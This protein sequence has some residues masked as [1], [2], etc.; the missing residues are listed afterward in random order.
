MVFIQFPLKAR[1]KDV[2]YNVHIIFNALLFNINLYKMSLV[3]VVF[4]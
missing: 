2:I 1:G 4:K 3:K